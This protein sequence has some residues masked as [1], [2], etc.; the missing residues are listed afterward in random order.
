MTTANRFHLVPPR[1]WDSIFPPSRTYI[2]CS[3]A[4]GRR[5]AGQGWEKHHVLGRESAAPG[6]ARSVRITGGHP[7]A[8]TTGRA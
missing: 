7:R 5:T 2:S 3:G 8:T 4:A 6:G 1:T